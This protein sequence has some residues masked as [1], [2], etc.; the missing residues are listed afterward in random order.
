MVTH[1]ICP[2]IRSTIVALCCKEHY[3]LTRSVRIVKC[4][5]LAGIF[6]I[7]IIT[8]LIIKDLILAVY[9]HCRIFQAI[10]AVSCSSRADRLELNPAFSILTAIKHCHIIK[11]KATI[12][13]S[14][15][16]TALLNLCRNCDMHLE[17]VIISLHECQYLIELI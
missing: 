8:V 9:D 17:S 7:H 15:S 4:H 3:R 6:I 16:V 11:R 2:L 13:V 10:I 14:H 1:H 5:N 12:T